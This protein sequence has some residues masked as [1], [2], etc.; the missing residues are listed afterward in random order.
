[1]RFA[2][3]TILTASLVTVGTN[4]VG[5]IFGYAREAT[6]ASFFGT[7]SLFDTFLLAF[8]VPEL[9]TFIIFAALPPALIPRMRKGESDSEAEKLAFFWNGLVSFAVIFGLISIVVYLLRTDI[10]LWLAPKLSEHQRSV[11]ERLMTILAGFVF[12]RGVEAFFRSC[13]F[14]RKHFIVP[15]TSPIIA[16]FVVLVLI[17]WLYNELNIEALAYGWLLASIA[18][19]FYNGVFAFL[20]VKPRAFSG[21]SLTS[22]KPLLRVT[23]TIAI[24]ECIGLIYPVID[25]YL[26]A[27]YLGEGQIAALR[28]A[29]FLV[30]VPIGMFAASFSMAAF[31]WISDLFA[32]HEMDRLKKLYR[33]SVRLI[34]FGMS[35]VV[36]AMVVFSTDVVRVAFLRG[37]FDLSSLH[38][39][40]GP[41]MYF[42]LGTVFYSVYL[43][44]MR[45][46]YASPALLR[47]GIILLIM[48]LIKT[49]M[50]LALVSSMGRNGLAIATSI[51]WLSGCVIMTID[52]QRTLKLS[53]GDLLFPF[54]LKVLLA[55]AGVALFWIGVDHFWTR[56]VFESLYVACARLA[57]L[58]LAGILLYFG[59]SAAL[60][61]SEPGRL[62][63][64]IGSWLRPKS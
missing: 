31:P 63:K 18:L 30:N 60:K 11:A 20:L 38:L 1:M 28:Y 3:Q 4:V 17:F 62:V 32:P 49:V 50:S 55:L 39:T 59:L 23:A 22:I 21:I 27:K 24:I 37:A 52:L 2:K 40:V 16:N 6:V 45:F 34:V 48:L 19:F 25:R 61:L 7:S 5:R 56:S 29:T 54:V 12:F 58:G 14:D 47:L 36:L 13:L 33:D 57:V 15:A 64:L 26:A 44:Q 42:A 10:L 53:D 35:F 8:T 51:A 41:F 43:Y 46:Y 9:M